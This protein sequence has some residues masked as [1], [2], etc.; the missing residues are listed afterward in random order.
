MK[1]TKHF[2]Y[3]ACAAAIG[4]ATGAAAQ[5]VTIN[6]GHVG[7]AANPYSWATEHFAEKV[8]EYTD[9]SVEIA[10]FPGA[11]LGGDRDLLE[12]IQLGS[13][14]AG[15]ISLAIWENLSPVL[16][17]FSMP[18]LIDSYETAY[19]AQTSDVAARA[20]EEFEDF[21]IKALAIVENGFRVPGNTVRPIR[22]PEDFDGI[23]FRAPE[24]PLLLSMFDRLGAIVT[25]M[26]YPEIFT[27]LQ[28]GVLQ[29]QDQ[30]L[31][32]WISHGAYDQ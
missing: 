30:F 31:N 6:L 17:G 15:Y 32:T 10:L 21:N 29:G 23:A 7:P 9:G 27:A 12:G 28:T 11:Q 26:P 5:D 16:T 13:V 14:E 22:T 20:L 19:E 25:P 3:L 1:M 2:K 8:A 24:A 18:F 4:M